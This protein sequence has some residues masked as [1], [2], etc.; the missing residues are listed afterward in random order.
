MNM[1]DD[2]RYKHRRPQNPRLIVFAVLALAVVISTIAVPG[3]THFPGSEHE[4]IATESTNTPKPGLLSSG[5]WGAEVRTW[6]AMIHYLFEPEPDRAT[7]ESW[8]EP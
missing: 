6:A 7:E 4:V 2:C 8:S 1:K 5:T 3:L